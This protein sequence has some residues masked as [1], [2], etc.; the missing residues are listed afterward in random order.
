[1]QVTCV[2][3]VLRA[4]LSVIVVTL[5]KWKKMGLWCKNTLT[6]VN[7][8]NGKTAAETPPVSPQVHEV[9]HC[10]PNGGFTLG[11]RARMQACLTQKSINLISVNTSVWCSDSFHKLCLS[12]HEKVISRMIH[13][14][15]CKLTTT[16]CI[17]LC[18]YARVLGHGTTL[19]M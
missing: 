4:Q 14:Y 5:R 12:A 1:M 11:A 17:G 13:V 7:S 10:L 3:A 2:F 6:R 15:M 8:W 9:H 16:H 18:T 19:L